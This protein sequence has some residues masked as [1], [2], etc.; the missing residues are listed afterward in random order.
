MGRL[1]PSGPPIAALPRLSP[2]NR[3]LLLKLRFLRQSSRRHRHRQDRSRDLRRAHLCPQFRRLSSLKER[4]LNLRLRHIAGAFGMTATAHHLG[5][6]SDA[7]AVSA[8]ILR[9]VGRHTA[10]GSV[11]AFLLIGHGSHSNPLGHSTPAR[12][13]ALYAG[14]RWVVSSNRTGL[15]PR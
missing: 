5:S 9:P 4:M 1:V 13:T 6:I 10:T 7:L 2:A 11:R 15:R 3:V 8:A 12:I 14:P